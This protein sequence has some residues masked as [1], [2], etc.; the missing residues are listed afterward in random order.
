MIR[1]AFRKRRWLA[2]LILLLFFAFACIPISPD[3]PAVTPTLPATLPTPSPGQVEIVWDTYGVPHIYG[4]TD[5]DAL[6]GF[7]Y[8]QARDHLQ[9][10]LQ[11]FLLAEGRLAEFFGPQYLTED[12]KARA[13]LPYSDEEL[14]AQVDPEVVELVDAFAQGIQAYMEEHRNTLPDW[15]RQQRVTAL[16]VL[17]FAHYAMIS[18][19]LGEGLKEWR[20]TTAFE[21]HP[22]ASNQWVVGI[23]RTREGVPMLLM[24]PHL[25]WSG[26]NRWYEAHLV[27]DTLNVYGATF[28]GLPFIVMGHN[29]QVA[30]ALTRNAPDLADVFLEE[31]HPENPRLYRTESGWEPMRVQEETFLVK[32]QG[33]VTRKIYT[34]RNGIVVDLDKEN[35]RAV[36]IALEGQDLYNFLAQLLAMNRAQ[37]MEEFK[38]AL[39]MHQVLLW[40]IMAVDVQGNMFYV[41]NARL[42]QRSEAW[43]RTAWRPGWNPQARWEDTIL[44]FEA[45]PQIENPPSDWMQ[46]NNVMPWFVTEGLTMNPQDYPAYLVLH[47]AS[48]NDRGQRA[49]QILAQAQGWT[50]QDALDLATDTY[51]LA[52]DDTLPALFA[53]YEAASPTRKQRL[54]PAIDLLRGWNRRADVDQPGMTLFVFWWRQPAREQDPL[55]ALEQAVDQMQRLYGTINIPWGDVHRIRRGQLDLPMAG[56]KPPASLWMAHG[57]VNKEGIVYVNAGS[58]FVMLV[59]L[60]PRVEAYSVKP[61][62]NSEDPSSPHYADQTPLMSRKELKPAWFYWEDVLAH[63]EQ[64]VVLERP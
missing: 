2:S 49:S 27:G 42:H 55:T 37:T 6:F 36:A 41:Y 32:G 60:G 16:R 64:I 30:W 57:P 10:M 5:K 7:G 15:A 45:L 43:D 28:Y 1:Q 63:A 40:N 20:G 31:L 24:D 52:A 18:R 14:M 46:N 56:S 38:D 29:G 12:L 33:K 9:D 3:P 48:M 13:V 58:S 62:G 53:A 25:P 61:Y 8:A 26:I 11:Q 34:T 51:I 23:S 47:E 35:H 50:L 21:S 4:A 19:A 54:Q 17:R 59:K 39:R 22:E 44:P